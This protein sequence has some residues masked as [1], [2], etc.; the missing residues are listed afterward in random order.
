M[1]AE[2]INLNQQN[3]LMLNTEK[4]RAVLFRP[5]NKMVILPN[6]DLGEG[7]IE[8]VDYIKVPGAHFSSNLTWDYHTIEIYKKLCKTVGAQNKCGNGLPQYIKRIIFNSLFFPHLT[9]AHLVWVTTT[10]SKFEKLFL[11]HKKALSVIA[12][13]PFNA[14]TPEIL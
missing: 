3:S 13:L 10:K 8:D 11:L 14:H 6:L 2:L 12:N 5:R 7:V 1:L 4:R 9:Y